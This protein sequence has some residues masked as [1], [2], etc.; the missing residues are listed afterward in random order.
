MSVADA[1][2]RLSDAIATLD[3]LDPADLPDEFTGDVRCS[4]IELLAAKGRCE[5]ALQSCG[6]TQ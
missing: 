6:G 3:E 5:V 1:D 2:R 4:Y